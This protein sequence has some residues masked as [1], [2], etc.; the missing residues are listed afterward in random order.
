MIWQHQTYVDDVR[1]LTEK[2]KTALI[3]KFEAAHPGVVNRAVH[4]DYDHAEVS[5]EWCNNDIFT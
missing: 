1:H 5:A 2:E 3:K 4:I